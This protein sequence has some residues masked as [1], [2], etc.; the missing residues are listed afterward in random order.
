MIMSSEKVNSSLLEYAVKELK[1][2]NYRLKDEINSISQTEIQK[3]EDLLNLQSAA[4]EAAANG[5]VITDTN[6]SIIWVNRAFTKLTGYSK[7]E[8]IN[9]NPRVLK[10]DQQNET[11]YKD[12]WDTISSGNVWK[13]ELINKRR[14]NS[15][16]TEELI[17]T[18]VKDKNGR[19]TNYIAIKQDI[20]K[21]KVVQEIEK[22]IIDT[23]NLDELLTGI[24]LSINKVV[25]APNF[26]IALMD[27]TS[28]I[29]SFPYFVDEYDFKPEPRDQKKNL[30]EYVIN[31]GKPLR[32]NQRIFDELIEK[33]EI[34]RIGQMPSS[35]IGIPLIIG[36]K[37]L[38]AMVIQRYD[39]KVKYSESQLNWLVSV[40]NQISSSI[41]RRK[42][43]EQI[44]YN[45]EKLKTITNSTIDAI[46]TLDED[47]KVILWNNAA[48]KIFEYS[49][50]EAIGNSIQDLIIP[51]NFQNEV[52]EIFKKVMGIGKDFKG[53]F[54]INARKKSGEVL[55]IELSVSLTELNN[56]WLITGILRDLSEINAL[57][58]NSDDEKDK[59]IASLKNELQYTKSNYDILNS[60]L[61]VLPHNIYVKDQLSR[62]TKVNKHMYEYMGCKTEQELLGKSDA[63]LFDNVQNQEFLN[64]EKEI[65][66]TGKAL[67]DKGHSEVL[68]NGELHW[69]QTS[70][71][72]LFNSDGK[73]IG[74][75]GITTDITKLKKS[76][77][78]LLDSHYR[79]RK[80]IEN[81]TLGII[82]LDNNGEII[83]V[84]PTFVTM[85]DYDS[86][87]EILSFTPEKIYSSSS[88]RKKFLQLLKSEE[89]ISG[90]EDVLI[91]KD[92][93]LIDVRESAWSIKDKNDQVIYYEVIIEDISEQNQILNILHESEFKYRTLLDKLNEAVFLKIGEKFEVVNTKFLELL[94]I[95]EEEV[96][97][98]NFD[99]NNFLIESKN[100]ASE[101]EQNINND[102]LHSNIFQLN[103]ITKNGLE[104]EVEISLSFLNF[105]GSMAEQ[106]I[107]RDLSNIKKQET[108]IRHLQKMEAIGTLA[109]GIAHE[110]NTPSQFVNDNLTFMKDA[111][112]D[113][114]PI[115]Q[116]IN[117]IE[118]KDEWFSD[119]A[120]L[121]K[122][123]DLEYLQEEIPNAIDQSLD[124]IKRI[125]NIVGAMRD[126]TH[127]GP[128]DKVSAD[129]HRII[130]N[131]ITLS[132]NTW[133]YIA[134]IET[135]FDDTI[136]NIICQPNDL[137]QVIINMIV[138]SSHAMEDKFAGSETLQGKIK[139]KTV[140][141]NDKVEIFISDN[142]IG[143]SE[144]VMKRIY[145]PFFTT[146]DV[147]KGTGQ[148]LSIA[149][150][151]I[152][153]KHKG[154][155]DV[156]SEVGIGTT[157]KITLPIDNSNMVN[158]D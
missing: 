100:F 85:L 141:Q 35:W 68:Q 54:K 39:K 127:T 38:G 56:K 113:I 106:G 93:T 64:E 80:L 16:Y 92:G 44:K 62:F 70:K 89:K 84:N 148:G 36:T 25:P 96:Y 88:N 13:G 34:D 79:F 99:L 37:S 132:K 32:L 155:I 28:G 111:Y 73:T 95:T 104:K 126:F 10:S 5:I 135:E 123:V 112:K 91:K 18:P 71:F 4:L 22:L 19:V 50:A 136:P 11:Y 109:A 45:E 149:Y 144:K 108:Q 97:N 129:V 33:K 31:S 59:I 152:V 94:E 142:G 121:A 120:K 74:T 146:K 154:E 21:Q 20:T 17:I 157:F 8:A 81:S 55:E 158:S 130:Q 69:A 48:E 67:V 57:G 102:D 90:F 66:R 77:Q 118:N 78:E 75:F 58:K 153:T 114:Q 65:M 7:E 140:N 115:F 116:L 60:I 14:D 139:I 138:N 143:M 1:Q 26:Y 51:D 125:A 2:E 24:H 49:E 82:R 42:A 12:L 124:G 43:E 23:T 151:I 105:K 128:K 101:S 98:D 145:D 76:E 137:N 107:I 41:Y 6:G 117:K 110:I 133:K 47:L 131:S 3:R 27:E 103:L 134:E 150:D 156:K 86:E 40:A 15:L 72:P 119:I 9:Q 83:M 87:A 30:T 46:I 61:E 122:S 147:G 29:V 63:D 53:T 52:N